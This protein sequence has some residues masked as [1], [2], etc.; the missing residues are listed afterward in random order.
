MRTGSDTTGGSDELLLIEVLEDWA[1]REHPGNP[2]IADHA[3]EAA[4]MALAGGASLFEAL[5]VGRA[6]ATPIDGGR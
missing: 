5:A 4:L 2:R 1:R 6:V 3:L